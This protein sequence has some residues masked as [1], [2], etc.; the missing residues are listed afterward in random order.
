MTAPTTPTIPTLRPG[1]SG[2]TG[3]AQAATA[4]G[5]AIYSDG[6]TAI[7]VINGG[8]SPINVTIVSQEPCD[9]GYTHSQVVAVGNGSN[10][11]I[12]PFA[13]DRFTDANGLVQISYSAVTSVTVE[14]LA[15]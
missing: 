9:Q 15:T 7:H 11:W 8:G 1:P 2:A 10:E 12:G 6:H 5:D 3:A 14:A 13:T 4:G